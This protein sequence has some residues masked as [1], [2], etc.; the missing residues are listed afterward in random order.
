MAGS[1]ATRSAPICS[2]RSRAASRRTARRPALYAAS[3]LASFWPG[4]LFAALAI[5][6][7]WR[8]RRESST[9]FALAAIL[10]HWIVYELIATKLPHY[11]LPAFPAIA[12]LTAAGLLRPA[13]FRG[14]LARA[15]ALLYGALWLACGLAFAAAGPV[16]LWRLQGVLPT[17]PIA[18]AVLA[19][20]LLVLAAVLLLR[21]QRPRAFAAAAG[22]ALVLYGSLFLLVVPDLDAIWLSPR[23]AATVRQVRPCPDSRL[24]SVSFSEPSLVFLVGRDTALIPPADAARFLAADPA[25]A[26]ALVGARDDAAFRAALTVPVRTI[27]TIDGINYSTGRRLRLSLVTA[28][29]RR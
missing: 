24:A 15:L 19:S 10:P 20:A 9:R 27:A 12:C 11:V 7:A 6:F 13:A 28:S 8:H 2:A 22:A 26:L 14:R 18:A 29:A 23:I 3:V 25:C 21:R 5:P 1:S 17:L 16:L 4:S